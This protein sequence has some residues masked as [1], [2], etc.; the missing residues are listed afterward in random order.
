MLNLVKP[1]SKNAA[2]LG[3]LAWLAL[4]AA[5]DYSS[6]Y[7]LTFFIFYLLPILYV[8]Q[9]AGLRW[10]FGSAILSI[11][12]WL[13]V[14]AAAGERYSDY[15]TPVWN[16]GIRLAV[17]ILIILLVSAR[18]ELQ[19]L[20]RQ[21]TKKLEEEI[22]QRR[23]LERELLEIAEVEQRR[24][25]HDLHDSLGQHL[26]AT[27]LAGKLLVKKLAD[28]PTAE[29][30]ARLVG[31]VEEAI[32][33]TRKLAHSMHPLELQNSGLSGALQKLAESV[34]KA[35]NVACRFEL[36]GSIDA[37]TLESQTHLYRIAQEA[38]SNA[39]RHGHARNILI[40]LEGAGTRCLLTVTDDGQGLPPDA[41]ERKGMGLRIMEYR[42]NLI[43]ASFDIQNLP[44][45]G[46]RAVC[47]LN[48]GQTN[49]DG[50]ESENENFA[51][52]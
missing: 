25:G 41:R 50:Y 19:M 4:V 21:R 9:G 28:H 6:G 47:V 29:S 14:N 30:A 32:E 31:L 22:E 43:G 3:G 5:A 35:F 27:A 11:F 16:A 36:V 2:L 10:A 17:F 38:V 46:L 1:K 52:G 37:G 39:I 23:R 15:L 12:T 26:T 24:I 45:G 42:A 34:S 20:V 8:L 48:P 13:F 44:A 33:L 49:S 40:S 18:T 51:G 7:E